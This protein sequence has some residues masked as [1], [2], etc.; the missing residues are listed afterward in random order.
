[1]AITIT[2]WNDLDNVRND[3]SADY[4]LANDLDTNT[5]GYS[6][7]A[8]SSANGGNGFDPIGNTSNGFTGSFDGQE[9]TISDLFID[10]PGAD[11][12]SLFGYAGSTGEISNIGVKNVDLNADSSVGGLVGEN[13]DAKI[14]NSYSTGNVG[15]STD[16]GGLV[17]E[18]VG[19]IISESY[20]TV[21][22][23]SD[24]DNVGGLVG[25]IRSGEISKSYSTGNVNGD[26]DCG[27]L[28]GELDS[29][30]K[31]F[32]SYSTGNVSGNFDVGGLV[33]V[34]SGTVTDSYW[35]TETSGQSS[36]AGGTGLTTSEMTGASAPSN[37]TGFDFSSVWTTTDSYPELSVFSDAFIPTGILGTVYVLVT[38]EGPDSASFG[39]AALTIENTTKG[40][41]LFDET[42]DRGGRS[43]YETGDSQLYIVSETAP[44]GGNLT[45]DTIEVT[46]EVNSSDTDGRFRLSFGNT[47]EGD[48]LHDPNPGIIEQFDGSTETPSNCDLIING[49]TVATDIGSGTFQTVVDISDQMDKN[50]W[51][52]YRV[53][54]DST[55]HI[56]AIPYVEGYRYVGAE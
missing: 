19:G 34:S 33:G 55:G 27:G 8:S 20:S 52:E 1:M 30:G 48:H 16:I 25:E 35:D 9:N 10:R 6:S 7:V 3:L 29:N 5:T 11:D 2:D 14:S 36:S 39:D 49:N 12:V 50:A 4:V 32:N 17:G 42:S 43:S 54:S 38:Y 41:V 56:L 18:N 53:T 51:N 46:L 26:A 22:V 44:D 21:D 23:S 37:M 31:I 47:L 15:G 45:G 24:N 28:V 13:R 40:N